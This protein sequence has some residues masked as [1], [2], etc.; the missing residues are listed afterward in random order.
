MGFH[1]VTDG[2]ALSQITALLPNIRSRREEI[3]KARRL[4]ADLVSDMR[5]AGVFRLGVPRVFGGDEASPM[6]I[7]R[8]IETIATADGSAGW[9]AM[10]G[11]TSNFSAGYMTEAGAREVFTDPTAPS[12][13]IAAP[14]GAAT[15]VEGG[16]RVTGRWP[17]ASGITHAEWVWAGC[18]VMDD[19][20]PK[21][22]P[23]GPETVHVWMPAR[24]VEIHDTWQVSGLCGTGSHD[25]SVSDAFV[26]ERRVFALLDQAGHRPEPLY[27]I[28]PVPLFVFQLVSVSLGIA[29][30]ALDELTQ[31]A[32][33]KVPS[34]H[35][36]PLADTPMMQ[37]E[38]ARAEAALGGARS[39]LYDVAQ[40]MWTTVCAGRPASSRQLALARVAAIQAAE[41]GATVART[42]ATLAGG[43][44]IYLKSSLQRHARDAQA[45][46][47]HFTVAPHTWIEAG[48]VLLGREP[49]VPVF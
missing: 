27:R 7:M 46:T 32:N 28:P 48:R 9:C 31:V 11:A 26:P 41:T 22:T 1:G 25:F 12:S 37:L 34:L 21:M 38:L 29:R 40:D 33:T 8:A 2:I 45:V 15:R 39:F 17:F 43:T 47:H 4:P 18:L 19:G 30:G 36:V 23:G 16:V 3:E 24:E 20:R 13:G 10:I 44:S 6:E 42:V 35:T 14:I 49:G 5:K